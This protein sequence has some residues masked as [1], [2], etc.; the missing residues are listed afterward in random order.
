MRVLLVVKSKAIETLG[1][2][3]LSAVIKHSGDECKIVDIPSAPQ[4]VSA[5]RPE[6]VGYSVMTG[7]QAKFLALNE[8]LKSLH[9]FLSVVGGPHATFFPRDFIDQGF[10]YVIPGEGENWF[11]YKW[12]EN[13]K[14]TKLDEMP[15]P[16]RTDFPGM[17]VRDFISSRGCFGTCTYCFNDRW[18]GL[19]PEFPRIRYRSPENV[20]EELKAVQAPYVYFQDSCFGVSMAWTRSFCKRYAQEISAPF[21]CHLRPILVTEERVAILKRANCLAVRMALETAST[22]LLDLLGRPRTASK[23]VRRASRTLRKY[24]IRYMIQNMLALPTSTIDDDLNTLEVNIRCQPDYAWA[25]IFSPFPGTALGDMC[26]TQG[27]Y[28]GDYSDI[29]DSFFD[30]SVLNFSEEYIEQTYVLQKIFALAVEARLMPEMDELTYKTMPKF[31]HRAM[32]KIGDGRLYGGY[33]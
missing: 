28:T 24:R 29:T 11:S 8:T 22:K 6:V 1:P 10:D 18:I 15:F 25:S 17:S 27:W 16:D 5:W 14:Y 19:F 32:R 30:K 4:V 21:Q 2:M 20:I 33:L 26:T 23:E 9:S 13:F 12:G 3:Y 31:I 7:D